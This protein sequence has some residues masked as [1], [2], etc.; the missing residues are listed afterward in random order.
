MSSV[1]TQDERPKCALC[2]NYATAECDVYDKKRQAI[3]GLFVCHQHKKKTFG[4]DCCPN[5][6]RS[7]RRRQSELAV[8]KQQNL[9]LQFELQGG[10]AMN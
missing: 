7:E 10:E 9:F 8:T 5:H 2:E 6:Y 1:L 4:V 3:C